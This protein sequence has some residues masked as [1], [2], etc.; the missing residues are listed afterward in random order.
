M[1]S[2]HVIPYARQHITAD[3]IESVV[4]VLKSDYLTQGPKVVEFENAFAKYVGTDFAVAVTNGT[5]ALH[6]SAMAL[7]VQ[8]GDRVLSTPNSFVASTNA[9][10]YCGGEVEFVD[11]NPETYLIDEELLEKKLKSRPKG[12]YRGLVAVDFAGHPLPLEKIS[13]LAREHGLFFIEDACHAFGA[14]Y[15][16]SNSMCGRGDYADLSVFSF[17]PVKHLATGEGGMITTNNRELYEKLT[18]LR[19]HGITKDPDR[20]VHKDQGGWY[21]E[22]QEL[23]YNYRMN[24]IQAAL[25]FSQLSTAIGGLEERRAIAKRYNQAFKNCP[26]IVTPIEKE[27]AKHSYHLY[28]PMVENR[29]ELYNFLKQRNIFAQIHYVPI[30]WHPYY[31]KLGHKKG[32]L[33]LAE[34]Y[35]G[36]CI[37]LPMFPTLNQDD[38]QYVIDTVLAFY[39]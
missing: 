1:K 5:A 22:M 12:Y 6:L 39:Q 23:G 21:Y 33:P 26:A 15:L 29:L 28:V 14:R 11:I 24:D 17:H 3:D 32:D 4:E 20:L 18:T 13:H 16:P 35:Y 30:H 2:P 31:E 27:W 36:K 38:Q 37:S 8:P 34:S 10:L 9:I 25:G 7:N 19:T